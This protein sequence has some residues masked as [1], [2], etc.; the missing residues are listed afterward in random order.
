MGNDA[1]SAFREQALSAW[2]IW[3]RLCSHGVRNAFARLGFT[4]LLAPPAPAVA[5]LPFI[6]SPTPLVTLT[7]AYLGITVFS[8]G[9]CSGKK[10]P[11][12][13][14]MAWFRPFVQVHNAFL[15]CLSSYMCVTIVREAIRHK[16]SLF[17]NEYVPSQTAMARYIYTF[18]AS[19][20][21]EF[22]DTV[23]TCPLP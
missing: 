22:L 7:L 18:Y 8:K 3:D 5:D 10:L 13:A 16:Y 15:V 20:M 21:Y 14:G 17:G 19:K 11:K 6:T 12:A 1:S 2:Q 4:E 9:L 23:R